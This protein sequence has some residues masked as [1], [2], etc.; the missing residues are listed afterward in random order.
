M[1]VSSQLGTK[2]DARIYSRV[3]LPAKDFLGRLEIYHNIRK[4][5]LAYDQEIDIASLF[6]FSSR[7]RTINKSNLDMTLYRRQ[8]VAQCVPDASCLDD[9][10]FEFGEDGRVWVGLKIDLS[11]ADRAPDEPGVGKEFELPLD[12]A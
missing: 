5:H 6:F 10:A 2:F 7:Y 9:Q 11:T 4:R 12:R 8:G 1:V 3:Y